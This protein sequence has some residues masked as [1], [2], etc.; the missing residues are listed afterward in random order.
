MR[1]RHSDLKQELNTEE[2]QLQLIHNQPHTFKAILLSL[3]S[4]E[5]R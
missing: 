3:V 4:Q 1:W 5:N 2:N